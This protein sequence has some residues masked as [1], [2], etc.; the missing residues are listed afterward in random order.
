MKKGE[1]WTIF[2]FGLMLLSVSIF[3]TPIFLAK[4]FMIY[5]SE[6]VVRMLIIAVV[7]AFLVLFINL[8]FTM[9]S[10]DYGEKESTT[11]VT[12]LTSL[13]VTAFE[14]ALLMLIFTSYT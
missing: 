11:Y 3:S 6:Y 1:L 7:I 4:F 13:I 12:F 10:S 2:S 5:L 14:I 9:S 8:F